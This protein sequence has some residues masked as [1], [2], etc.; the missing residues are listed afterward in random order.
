ME[1]G[2]NQ[3]TP[4]LEDPRTISGPVGGG[5]ESHTGD[6]NHWPG[7]RPGAEFQLA[8]R[9]LVLGTGVARGGQGAI[10]ACAGS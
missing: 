9:A 4:K 8:L 3:V 10:P 1:G 5:A 7:A 2:P 6:G